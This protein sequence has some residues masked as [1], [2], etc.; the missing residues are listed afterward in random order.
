MIITLE[1]DE[2]TVQYACTDGRD[3]SI[4]AVRAVGNRWLCGWFG[5]LTAAAV[6]ST[7]TAQ[8]MSHPCRCLA[9]VTPPNF[10]MAAAH[11]ANPFNTTM[12]VAVVVV[13][14]EE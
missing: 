3:A 2:D 1:D 10:A 13:V 6:G 9:W 8:G 7:S 12:G 14:E 4:M 5:S 11:E